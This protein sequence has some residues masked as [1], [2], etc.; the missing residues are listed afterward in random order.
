MGRG[1]QVDWMDKIITLFR[2]SLLNIQKTPVLC[3]AYSKNLVY[4][5][6]RTE[7]LKPANDETNDIA[8]CLYFWPVNSGVCAI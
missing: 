4:L 3:L 6:T 2:R 8:F 7:Q 1:F 5:Q